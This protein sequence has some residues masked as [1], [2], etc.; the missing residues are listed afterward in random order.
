VAALAAS[1]YLLIGNS[2]AEAQDLDADRFTFRGFGTLG[3]V[4][5][6]TDGIAYRRNVGQG[7]GAEAGTLDLETDSVAGLQINTRL[8][9]KF[10]VVLQ[11]VTR[12]RA[13]GDWNP[14]LLQG[15]LRFSPDDAL[16]LRAGRIGYDIY[17][18]AESRQVGY[19]YLAVRP[20]PEFYGQI[21]ND[22]IDGLDVAYTR[23]LGRGL[24]K[25]RVFA[26]SSSGEMAFADHTYTDAVGDIYGATFDYIYRGWTA[27][28]ALAQFN[29]DTD[30]DIRLLAGALRATG[31]P[32]AIAVA[33]DIDHPAVRAGGI[34]VGVAYDDG[35][36]L[37]QLMYGAGNSDSIGGP[38]FDKLYALFGYRFHKWTPFASFASSRD[39]N[40]IHDAG[41]PDIPMLAPLNAAVVQIQR[42]TRSTQRS[43][44]VGVRYD[45]NS[46][47]DFKF[48][49]DRTH[50]S[51]SSLMFDY[52]PDAGTPCD[53]TVISAA[54]DF[55][56]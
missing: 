40:P 1:A 35:P 27:R 54:V 4:R 43:T 51:D 49:A 39:R 19:S 30:A 48:Q 32:S 28:I 38:D 3:V 56:F 36:M 7:G 52:R 2:T 16:V 31:M 24:F 26:G 17:L 23:R 42:G 55:V 46:H 12:Q 20:S 25:A 47:V 15:Y 22:D 44:S 5:H 37:A 14:R 41:L 45:F 10:D 18:L 33:D 13:D 8:S 11:G 29:Y 21:T 50:V 53:L 9:D 34:Q 6:D